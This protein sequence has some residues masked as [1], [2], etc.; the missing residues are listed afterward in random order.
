MSSLGAFQQLPSEIRIQIY[1]FLF[2]E[3]IV[4]IRTLDKLSGDAHIFFTSN[5]FAKEGILTGDSYLRL[6]YKA[7]KYVI[8]C[9]QYWR[10]CREKCW[11]SFRPDE[12]LPGIA[13]TSQPIREE[14]RQVF[15]RLL[16]QAEQ[17]GRTEQS[18][19][20]GPLREGRT[21]V[22]IGSEAYLRLKASLPDHEA[23]VRSLRR[24]CG[25]Q[26]PYSLIIKAIPINHYN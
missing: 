15:I 6:Q 9:K 8:S 23:L 7:K 25:E 19:Q 26:S 24:L 1:E 20:T 3:A 10:K 13:M 4:A 12:Q 21:G 17:C 18:R 16:V 5:E 2:Q 22:S 11:K 14:A